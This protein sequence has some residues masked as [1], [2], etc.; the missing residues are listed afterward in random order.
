METPG[1]Y[2]PKIHLFGTTFN[3]FFLES[4]DFS[5][6]PT[7]SLNGFNERPTDGGKSELV[8]IPLLWK[9]VETIEVFQQY[10]FNDTFALEDLIDNATDADGA[11]VGLDSLW[12]VNIGI[13]GIFCG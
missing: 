10:F 3:S 1:K 12:S 13:L 11:S 2:L 8:P 7:I 5:K 6:P 4:I 9:Q